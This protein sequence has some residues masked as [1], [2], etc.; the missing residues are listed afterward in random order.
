MHRLMVFVL[1]AAL[2]GPLADTLIS[3]GSPLVLTQ[4]K[5]KDKKAKEKKQGEQKSPA[6]RPDTKY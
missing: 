2:V 4:E 1:A 3:D 6:G 5:G